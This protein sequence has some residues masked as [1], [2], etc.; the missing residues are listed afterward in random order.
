MT[1]SK[2]FLLPR[3]CFFG[4]GN[5]D[6]ILAYYDINCMAL[7]DTPICLGRTLSLRSLSKRAPTQGTGAAQLQT[8]VSLFKTCMGD[9]GELHKVSITHPFS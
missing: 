1:H 4:A 8:M 6:Q 9:R 7:H 3:S 2:N 5:T